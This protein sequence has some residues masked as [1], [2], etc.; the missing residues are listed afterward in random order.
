MFELKFVEKFKTHFIFHDFSK[1]VPL[2]EIMWKN[3]VQLD[4]PQITI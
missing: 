1:I 4:R 3:F 2:Y